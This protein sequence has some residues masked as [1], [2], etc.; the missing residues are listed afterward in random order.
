MII[1]Q[2]KALWKPYKKTQIEDLKPG[3]IGRGL[4]I[5]T[6]PTHYCLNCNKYLGFKGFCSEKCHDEHN[7]LK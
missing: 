2:L 3:K 6:N 1:K 4:K 7:E 5:H